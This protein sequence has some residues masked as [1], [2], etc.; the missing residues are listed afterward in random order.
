MAIGPTP[1]V[2]TLSERR[3]AVGPSVGPPVDVQAWRR[4]R[5][6]EAGFPPAL[7]ATVAADPRF[8]LHALLQLVD[9]GCP[10]DLAVR[11]VAPL[12]QEMAP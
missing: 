5:L 1:K 2:M 9:R 3:G 6:R 8:D 10:P 11:I 12:P 4:C 7:A